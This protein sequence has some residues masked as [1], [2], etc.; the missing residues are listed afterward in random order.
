MKQQAGLVLALATAAPAVAGDQPPEARL[1]PDPGNTA[2]LAARASAEGAE[3]ALAEGRA[4]LATNNAVQAISAFRLALAADASSVAAL[5]GL[6]IAYDRLGRSDL[7]RRHFE[8]ALAIEPDAGDIAYNLGWSLH[9]AS[10]DRGA[11]PWLQRASGSDDGRAAAA[12]R[13]VLA[14]IAARLEAEASGAVRLPATGADPLA[15]QPIRVASARIDMA[16]TG[17]AVL[18]LPGSVPHPAASRPVLAL[19]VPVEQVI[20]AAALPLAATPADAAGLDIMLPQVAGPEALAANAAADGATADGAAA[21]ETAAAEA[22]APAGNQLNS[23]LGTLAAL[24][25]PLAVAAPLPAV[26]GPALPPPVVE[27]AR[28]A[29]IE[30]EAADRSAVEATEPPAPLRKRL[31]RR[32]TAVVGALASPAV[33]EQARPAPRVI[34]LGTAASTLDIVA[35]RVPV[36]AAADTPDPVLANTGDVPPLRLLDLAALPLLATATPTQPLPLLTPPRL[37]VDWLAGTDIDHLAPDAERPAYRRLMDALTAQADL[38]DAVDP[39]AVR[40]AIS[41]LEAL[42]ARIELM[43]REVLRA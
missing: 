20:T 9:L 34:A 3:A 14:L 5:N 21:A 25:I 13:R 17:E 16:S 30:G 40:M 23:R 4:Y 26:A 36:D 42:V 8:M 41:R 11:V 10:D 27:V 24:T 1:L 28:V 35:E 2:A 37:A 19:S 32:A 29:E 6:G 12:A 38:A 43:S 15:D 7:A 18:V 31:L 22:V 39:Q 33:A